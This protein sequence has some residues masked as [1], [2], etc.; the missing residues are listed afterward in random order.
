MSRSL[1]LLVSR[2]PY[3]SLESAEAI[4]HARGAAGKGWQV[5]LALTGESV[6][7]LLPGQ[8][9]R[10]GEWIGLSHAVTELIEEGKDRV[11][12][13][14]EAP[15][16]T[17]VGLSPADLIPGVRPASLDDIAEALARTDRTL[18]F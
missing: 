9:P 5:V 18:V 4:R 12:V 10:A 2:A 17:A 7:T 8:S 1:C 3:G 16:L 13:L 14:A 11:Q 6:F 15:A